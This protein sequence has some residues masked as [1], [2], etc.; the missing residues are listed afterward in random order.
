MQG[1]SL[2]RVKE[3]GLAFFA[4]GTVLAIM[5]GLIAFLLTWAGLQLFRKTN[6]AAI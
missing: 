4:G 2:A 3:E 6:P 5:M 1:V